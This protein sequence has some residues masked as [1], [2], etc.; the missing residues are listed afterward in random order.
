MNT[1]VLLAV[2][3]VALALV[4]AVLL[5]KAVVTLAL[6]AGAVWALVA[7]GGNDAVTLLAVTAAALAVLLLMT[8]TR[9]RPAAVLRLRPEEVTA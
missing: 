3:G 5:W 8:T 4:L 9:R 6:V 1:L 7:H 2:L